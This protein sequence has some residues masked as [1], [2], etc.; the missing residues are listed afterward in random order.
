MPLSEMMVG[1]DQFAARVFDHGIDQGAFHLAALI[2]V[3]PAN[4][5]AD[6]ERGL[7]AVEFVRLG[8]YGGQALDVGQFR[9]PGRALVHDVRGHAA[10]AEAFGPEV[11]ALPDPIQAGGDDVGGQVETL[12]AFAVRDARSF[13]R[14]ERRQDLAGGRFRGGHAQ[15]FEKHHRVVVQALAQFRA[16]VPFAGDWIRCVVVHIFTA[17]HGCFV[18]DGSGPLVPRLCLGTKCLRGS[19][20]RRR[21][22]Q[23]SSFPAGVREREPTGL[24]RSGP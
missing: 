16:A 10:R 11:Q 20:S 19:A 4:A 15:G 17:D 1:G 23:F 22:R 7:Q 8:V 2:H 9:T 18:N 3:G 21:S 14:I 6:V 5:V 12:F 13:A 24:V